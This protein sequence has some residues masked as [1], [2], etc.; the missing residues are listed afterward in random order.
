MKQEEIRRSEYQ[1]IPVEKSEYIK[2]L[3]E[4][5]MKINAVKAAILTTAPML[6]C[7]L[8]V[9]N[10]RSAEW[11]SDIDGLKNYVIT[12]LLLDILPMVLML[13][14]MLKWVE[15]WRVASHLKI[16][17]DEFSRI[18]NKSIGEWKETTKLPYIFESQRCIQTIINDSKILEQSS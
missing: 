18:T 13:P 17:K 7:I 16:F 4:S 3:L 5:S 2:K 12:Y 11:I 1:E 14:I 6:F 8:K 10:L 15:Y 9:Q